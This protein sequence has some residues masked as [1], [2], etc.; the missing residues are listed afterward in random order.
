MRGNGTL[1][2]KNISGWCGGYGRRCGCDR[3]I[4]LIYRWLR[5]DVHNSLIFGCRPFI[6]KRLRYERRFVKIIG[7]GAKT[8]FYCADALLWIFILCVTNRL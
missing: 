1:N 3:C 8:G 4:G 6:F 2:G 7:G 5:E